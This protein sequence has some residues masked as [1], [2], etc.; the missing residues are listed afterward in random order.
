MRAN[1][2]S[3]LPSRTLCGWARTWVCTSGRSWDLQYGNT[4]ALC[5]LGNVTGGRGGAAWSL[6]LQFAIVTP[7]GFLAL[8]LAWSSSGSSKSPALPS[9][10][11]SMSEPSLCWGDSSWTHIPQHPPDL[12]SPHGLLSPSLTCCNCVT[13][14]AG[15]GW[16]SDRDPSLWKWISGSQIPVPGLPMAGN[17]QFQE[18]SA[19]L[20]EWQPQCSPKLGGSPVLCFCLICCTQRG[21]PLG[22]QDS[23][24]AWGASHLQHCCQLPFLTPALLFIWAGAF[25]GEWAPPAPP[26]KAACTAFG[27]AWMPW[28]A[29]SPHSLLKPPR[30]KPA[31]D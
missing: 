19:V 24:C 6:A 30:C 5:R 23:S 29:R 3:G 1:H 21:S 26:F 14:P 20:Y 25:Q 12:L 11:C 15:A 16:D 8:A 7:D 2:S 18:P 31:N 28:S 22:Q 27:C 4:Q 10:A 17:K 9:R 13:Q